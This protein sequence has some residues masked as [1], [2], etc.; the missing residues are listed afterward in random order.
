VIDY[1]IIAKG[2]E[3]F[4]VENPEISQDSEVYSSKSS[5]S[6]LRMLY[7]DLSLDYLPFEVESKIRAQSKV[8]GIYHGDTPQGYGFYTKDGQRFEIITDEWEEIVGEPE[9]DARL[10]KEVEAKVGEKGLKIILT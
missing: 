3:K 9:F 8:H 2:G 6:G 1:R 10:A 4:M 7:P 5:G